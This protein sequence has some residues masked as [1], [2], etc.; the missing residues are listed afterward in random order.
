MQKTILMLVGILFMWLCQQE[1]FRKDQYQN[2]YRLDSESECATRYI[3]L[4]RGADN[5]RSDN[6]SDKPV[7]CQ[8]QYLV[9]TN[10]DRY[11]QKHKSGKRGHHKRLGRTNY[12]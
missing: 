7:E 2:R 6:N 9:A 10:E 8:R 5:G 11:Q 12:Y 1:T 4:S 3:E